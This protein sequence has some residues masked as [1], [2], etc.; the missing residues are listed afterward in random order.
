MVF[1]NYFEEGLR[2]YSDLRMVDI[3]I[4]WCILSNH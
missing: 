1:K 4:V 3:S 2:F